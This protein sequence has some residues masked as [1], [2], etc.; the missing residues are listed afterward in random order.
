M[1]TVKRQLRF[2]ELATCISVTVTTGPSFVMCK[3][4]KWPCLIWPTL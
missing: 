4:V 1:R 2:V 3:N